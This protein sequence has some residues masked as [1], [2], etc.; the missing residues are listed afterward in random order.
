MSGYV[1]EIVIKKTWDGD[2]VTIVM[3]PAKFGDL[4]TFGGTSKDG[5]AQKLPDW[6]EKLK[7]YTKT[8]SGLKAHDASEVTVDEFYD[9]AYFI[10]LVTD[11]LTEW[12]EKATPAN[13]PS[14]GA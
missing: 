12:L 4:L 14:P 9:S 8:L 3:K 10:E 13:P 6:S 2:Q 7:A 11:V 5:I 1:R